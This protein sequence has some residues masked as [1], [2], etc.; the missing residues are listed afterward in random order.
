MYDVSNCTVMEILHKTNRHRKDGNDEMTI[1][2]DING[3]IHHLVLDRYR[4]SFRCDGTPLPDAHKMEALI[5][6]D[7]NVGQH[8]IRLAIAHF[9]LDHGVDHP[10]TDQNVRDR[11]V[12]YITD[13][14]TVSYRTATN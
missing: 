9:C 3:S 1:V 2:A 13:A 14:A 7:P 12:K 5:K 8:A 4:E 6:R 11:M 10:D